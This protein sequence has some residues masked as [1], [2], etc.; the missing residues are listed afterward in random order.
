M[1]SFVVVGVMLI[2]STVEARGVGACFKKDTELGRGYTRALYV[3]AEHPDSTCRSAVRTIKRG[4]MRKTGEEYSYKKWS[5]LECPSHLG[6]YRD[7]AKEGG[8]KEGGYFVIVYKYYSERI[9]GQQKH[10]LYFGF[11]VGKTR[12][13][14]LKRALNSMTAD[15]FSFSTKDYEVYAEG[16]F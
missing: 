3:I 4:M 11:S 7:Y 10:P 2:S 6:D 14:A 1:I 15:A 8:Y 16:K 13:I 5:C 12:E 9:G